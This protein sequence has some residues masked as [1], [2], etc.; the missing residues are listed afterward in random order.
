MGSLRVGNAPCSWGT[1]EFEGAKGEQIGFA[2][3]LDELAATGYTGTELGDWGYMPTDPEAL[4]SE[5]QS[6][7][8]TMLGAFVPVALKDPAAHPAGVEHALRVARLLAAVATEPAPYLVLADNNGTVP[9]RTRNAG[10]I[11]PQMGLSTEEWRVFAAGAN[12]VAR[13]VLRETGL[14]TVFHHH[15]AGYVETPDEIAKFLDATDPEAIGLVFDTG[16]YCY[17][18]GGGDVIEGLKRFRQRVWYLHFKDCQPEVAARARAEQ[19]DYFQALRHGVFCELGKGCVDFQSVLRWMRDTGYGGYAL[20]EQDVLP[21][22]GTPEASA[23]HN[24]EYLRSIESNYSAARSRGA[25]AA[26]PVRVGIIGAGRI[27]KVH[28]G[29]LAHRLPEAVP[30][31]IMDTNREAARSLADSFRI[32]R[33]AGS[34]AEILAAPDIDAVLICSST[35]THAGLVEQAAQAGKHIFCEKPIDHSL[36]KID[37][38]LEAVAK[39]GVKLQVGFNRR[40]DANFARVR[41]AV[42]SGEIGT[43]HLLHIVSRD[44]APPPI[45]YI[46]TSGGIFLDM[47]I[48]DFDMARFLIGDEV[49]EIYTAAAVR[50]DPAIGKAGDLDTAVIVLRFRNSV[51]ATIDNSRKA[52]YGY[53]QRVEILGSEGSIATGNCYPNEAVISTASS[54]RKDLPLN[55][56]ME[57]YAESFANELR[58]F[59]QAV[60]ED[61]ATPVTGMDGRIPVVMAL[62]ARRSY[63][64]HR[65]VRLEEIGAAVARV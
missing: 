17:G 6:R 36:D 28:A 30:V 16:H 3:M 32:G 50:V 40:F 4:R 9:E 54:V 61:K 22:M 11:T 41:R 27:G 56:F 47:T 1:L 10:R 38:A 29:T 8:L 20:V 7:G 63:D 24:R 52:V 51:I 31:A 45:A 53:D 2:R 43:P 48:H 62:A 37:R 18:S 33:V 14:R 15:C 26:R 65:P 49:E 39:A 46:E 12:L 21:G 44:P 42:E 64:E 23:R 60:R 59:V 55:F 35:A 5:L 25:A 34:A 19:W 13:T 58:A 57:R